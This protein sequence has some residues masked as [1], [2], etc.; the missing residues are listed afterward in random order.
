M[1][2]L[3]MWKVVC[4]MMSG[5]HLFIYITIHLYIYNTSDK[6]RDCDIKKNVMKGM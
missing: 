2:V 4:A 1:W 3:I 6:L 5:Q